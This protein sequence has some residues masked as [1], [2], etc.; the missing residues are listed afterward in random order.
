MCHEINCSFFPGVSTSLPS[1]PPMLD[2]P[3]VIE[4]VLRLV[5][6]TGDP[7]K[8]SLV[9]CAVGVG[10][11]LPHAIT[12]GLFTGAIRGPAN[13]FRLFTISFFDQTAGLMST[14]HTNELEHDSAVVG[15]PVPSQ[16]CSSS[17]L[18]V[19]LVFP[20]TTHH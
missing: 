4:S 18:R 1:I 6:R 3:V 11:R 7:N 2:Q 13:H 14:P 17:E 15:V 12:Y 20:S 10:H 8:H 19:S 9:S 5:M 16:G